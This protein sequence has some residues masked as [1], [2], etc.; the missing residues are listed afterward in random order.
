MSRETSK[1]PIC[2]R[3]VKR[4]DP[5][6]PFCSERCRYVDLGRWLGGGYRVNQ[7][8]GKDAEEKYA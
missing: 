8:P 5:E 2:S 3:S 4:D 1:C 6:F 7:E